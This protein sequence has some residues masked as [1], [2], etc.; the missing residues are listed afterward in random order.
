MQAC[1]F[2]VGDFIIYKPSVIGRGKIIMTDLANLKPGER[3]KIARIDDGVYV[4]VEGFE[5]S[6]PSGLYWT[7]FVE[8]ESGDAN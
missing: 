1:P 7:E 2:K 4:V 6:I 3:Y 5:N 8:G